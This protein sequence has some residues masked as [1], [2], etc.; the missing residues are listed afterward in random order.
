MLQNLLFSS[1]ESYLLP[2]SFIPSRVTQ[3]TFFT[4]PITIRAITLHAFAVTNPDYF[5]L[6]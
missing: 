6:F 4:T 3:K 2:I 1:L 5:F